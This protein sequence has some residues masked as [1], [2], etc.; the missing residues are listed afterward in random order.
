[1]EAGVF[2]QTHVFAKMAMV[3]MIA[4]INFV[5]LLARMAEAALE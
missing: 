1:M 3:E 5:R 4:V 2:G